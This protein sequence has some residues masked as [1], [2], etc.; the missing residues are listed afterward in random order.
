[1]KVS[2]GEGS[3]YAINN[4]G[5]I[6]KK[7]IQ[8]TIPESWRRY[9]D[10]TWLVH[11]S[12]LVETVKLGYQVHGHVDY[13]D[14]PD[15]LQIK[16]AAQRKHARPTCEGVEPPFTDDYRTLYLHQDA[17]PFIVEAA[18]K[19]VLKNWHPDKAPDREQEF[20]RCK[21]AYERIKEKKEHH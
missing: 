13:S 12:K 19:S 16:I 6:V 7:Y 18:W 11:E 14:L 8:Y 15:D 4:P 3:F 2:R 5:K 10:G 20:R 9:E 17:P 21:D 1:M